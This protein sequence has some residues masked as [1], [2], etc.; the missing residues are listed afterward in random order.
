M[1]KFLPIVVFLYGIFQVKLWFDFYNNTHSSLWQPVMVF[2]GVV[3]FVSWGLVFYTRMVLPKGHRIVISMYW[4]VSF[5]TTLH[6]LYSLIGVLVYADKD[7]SFGLTMG[8]G[9]L[10]CM[11]S[12][13]SFMEWIWIESK[14]PKKPWDYVDTI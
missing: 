6:L 14:K 2:S 13:L 11:F 1:M 10:L 7:D 8:I 4:V 12:I 5:T 3:Q 9:S